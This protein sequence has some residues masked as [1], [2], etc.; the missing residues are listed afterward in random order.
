MDAI[1]D[2]WKWLLGLGIAV[3][4]FFS[5]RT[6]KAYDTEMA[7]LRQKLHIANHEIHHL[8]LKVERLETEMEHMRKGRK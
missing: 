3:I 8:G 2:L 5:M 6:L 1:A 4:G 7:N